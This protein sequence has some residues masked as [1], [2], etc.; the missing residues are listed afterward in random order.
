[1]FGLYNDNIT[2]NGPNS[3]EG[4]YIGLRCTASGNLVCSGQIKVKEFEGED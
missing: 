2:L 1:M 3:I 4:K